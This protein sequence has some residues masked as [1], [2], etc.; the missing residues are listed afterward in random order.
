MRPAATNRAGSKSESQ[1]RTDRPSGQ[2]GKSEKNG[3]NFLL[4]KSPIR[5]ARQLF[6][7]EGARHGRRRNPQSPGRPLHLLKNQSC[8]LLGALGIRIEAAPGRDRLDK[9]LRGRF[10]NALEREVT[11]QISKGVDHKR[12]L[13]AS[14]LNDRIPDA[15][16]GF[17]VGSE[18]LY[19]P[20]DRKL[21]RAINL[22]RG[23][24]TI[25]PTEVTVMM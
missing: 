13:D 11:V 1:E 5:I 21:G 2:S 3:S 14:R 6:F 22:G 19:Q 17:E 20:F 7:G 8:Y 9:A 16:N 10:I 15:I 23:C 4:Q 18:R 24:P 12:G 25:P